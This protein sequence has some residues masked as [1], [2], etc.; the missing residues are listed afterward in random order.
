MQGLDTRC[1]FALLVVLYPEIRFLDTN[2]L[3][4]TSISPNEELNDILLE[5]YLLGQNEGRSSLDDHNFHGIP[6]MFS[7]E[8][9]L[10]HAYC[11]GF[12]FAREYCRMYA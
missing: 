5:V 6:A 7:D 12:K 11:D 4:G 1:K 10:F 2:Q 3:Y 8:P 9:L